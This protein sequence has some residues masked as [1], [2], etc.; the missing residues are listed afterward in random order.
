M[1]YFFFLFFL[2]HRDDLEEHGGE[3]DADIP[4]ARGRCVSGGASTHQ[5]RE[6]NGRREDAD[7]ARDSLLIHIFI[8]SSFLVRARGLAGRMTRTSEWREPGEK[9]R[10][11]ERRREG[12]RKREREEGL[13]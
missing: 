5:A 1:W 8:L 4:D 7:V 10:A 3:R 9:R 2:P 13:G 6:R 12:E 11:R